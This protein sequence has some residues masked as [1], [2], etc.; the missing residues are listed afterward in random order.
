[1][2]DVLAGAGI[3]YGDIEM[4]GDHTSKRVVRDWK[5]GEFYPK[6]FLRGWMPA[7]ATFYIR[8][9]VVDAVG[10]F[11]TSYDIGS[12]YDF[13]LRAMIRNFRVRYIKEILIDFQLG[14]KSSQG[15]RSAFHQNVKCLR[16]RR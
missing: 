2:V 4:V 8:R 15:L 12:D 6:A 10:F 11:D 16:S 14:G 5:S 1:M 3:V 9:K 7:H 13:I